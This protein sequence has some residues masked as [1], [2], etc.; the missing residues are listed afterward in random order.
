VRESGKGGHVTTLRPAPKFLLP[1]IGLSRRGDSQKSVQDST[2]NRSHHSVSKSSLYVPSSVQRSGRSYGQSEQI[3]FL[4]SSRGLSR[5]TIPT[6]LTKE[7][8][9]RKHDLRSEKPTSSNSKFLQQVKATDRCPSAHMS[10]SMS[11]FRTCRRRLLVTASSTLTAHSS[12]SPW[13]DPLE[14]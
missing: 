3:P 13:K 4:I 8:R 7:F 2:G 12:L 1:S 11:T 5:A 6:Q 10:L 14:S 9:P